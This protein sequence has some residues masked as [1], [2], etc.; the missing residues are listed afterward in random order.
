MVIESA[1]NSDCLSCTS[2]AGEWEEVVKKLPYFT[3]RQQAERGGKRAAENN[4]PRMTVCD[5]RKDLEIR[6][7]VTL[8]VPGKAACLILNWRAL[9]RINTC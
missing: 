8:K 2:C 6:G 5:S 3:Y 7:R 9:C 1:E 4:A